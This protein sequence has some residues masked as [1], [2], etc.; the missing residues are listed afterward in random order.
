M[1]EKQRQ[2]W[3]GDCEVGKSVRFLSHHPFFLTGAFGWVVSRRQNGEL[4]LYMQDGEYAY[5]HWMDTR[6]F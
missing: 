1:T 3:L 4:L 6:G 5:V 2:R